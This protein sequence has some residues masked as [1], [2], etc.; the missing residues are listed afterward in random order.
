MKKIFESDTFL[1]ILS[2]MIAVI[3]WLYI[4]V[5]LDPAV[6]VEVRDL[7]IQ[8]VGQEQLEYN[9]ISVV[10]ES[11]TT[12]NLKVKGSRKKMGRYDMKT[13][14]AKVDMSG[15]WS[16]GQHTLP[17]DI[18]VP[19]ENIGISSQNIYDVDIQT[20]KT[21]RKKLE[22]EIATE[23]SPAQNYMPGE[24]EINPK[25]VTIKGPESVVGKIEKAGVVLNY[26]NADVDITQELPIQFYDSDEKQLTAQDALLKR[27]TQDVDMATV[28][29][30]VVKLRT[31]KIIPQF[32]ADTEEERELLANTSYTL[33]PATIQIYGEDEVTAKI[34]E[35]STE[36]IPME[37]FTDNHK[38]KVRLILPYDVKVLK[39]IS[40]VEITLSR[41]IKS[42]KE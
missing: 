31:V 28:E 24:M 20:E 36:G 2:V 34:T 42:E 41:S 1:K 14:I 27:I 35:I 11:A 4:I 25:T 26:G 6:E 32:W 3:L 39:D 40:E 7:P 38:A 13:I 21:V 10:N 22:L 9:G 15:V 30:A 37:K 18:V 17:V 19:F 12:I 29:C 33:N 23:G 16:V 5:V 8:F